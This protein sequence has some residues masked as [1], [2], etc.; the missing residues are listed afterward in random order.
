MIANTD[1]YYNSYQLTA[2][3][4]GDLNRP[5]DQTMTEPMDIDSKNNA[6]N[7]PP[8]PLSKPDVP[9]AFKT[10]RIDSHTYLINYFNQ[11]S[12]IEF[13][14]QIKEVNAI[15]ALSCNRDGV[16]L[17]HLATARQ[18]YK[19]AKYLLEIGLSPNEKDSRGQTALH[20]ACRYADDRIVQLFLNNYTDIEVNVSDDFGNTP[21][22]HLCQNKKITSNKQK[23]LDLL[24]A[25]KAN[26]NSKNKRGSTPLNYAI[27]SED[28]SF[29]YALKSQG[30]V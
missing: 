23:I 6:D 26:I 19:S 1:N 8:T 21:L 12:S 30:A 10:K 11:L 9:A 15:K 25:K 28:V 29:I 4:N 17:L 13:F 7:Q 24:V 18:D 2:Y 14:P 16:D 27:G 3:Y 5:F 20:C 22:H